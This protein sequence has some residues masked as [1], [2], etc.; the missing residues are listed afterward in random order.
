MTPTLSGP[1]SWAGLSGT[2]DVATT[3]GQ[4]LLDRGVPGLH[5]Y[6]LNAPGSARQVW[7]N[8]GLGE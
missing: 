2:V 8:L 4:Q 3:I 5:I 6:T 7:K 1:G